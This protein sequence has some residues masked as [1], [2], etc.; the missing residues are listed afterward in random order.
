M[1]AGEAGFGGVWQPMLRAQRSMTKSWPCISRDYVVILRTHIL[2]EQDF[3]IADLNQRGSSYN[4]RISRRGLDKHFEISVVPRAE[5]VE[6]EEP[7]EMQ[8]D[9]F[10]ANFCHGMIPITAAGQVAVDEYG[11]AMSDNWHDTKA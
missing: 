1:A 7:Q 8:F 5:L 10:G 4:L 11:C 9:V 3:C 2:A 6:I